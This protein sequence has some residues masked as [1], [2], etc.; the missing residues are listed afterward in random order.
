MP[1]LIECADTY[2]LF[3]EAVIDDDVIN[4][5]KRMAVEW[6]KDVNIHVIGKPAMTAVAPA[7]LDFIEVKRP[8][9]EPDV[10]VNED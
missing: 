6:S 8:D 10:P 5:A 2:E 3:T 9:N 1:I 7:D 4:A